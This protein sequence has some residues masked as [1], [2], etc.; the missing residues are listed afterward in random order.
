MSIGPRGQPVSGLAAATVL[1]YC[2]ST[3]V[4]ERYKKSGQEASS[5]KVWERS[6]VEKAVERGQERYR[7][8]SSKRAITV[9]WLPYTVPYYRT[10]I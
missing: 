1:S 5:L 8:L 7:L 9:S 10:K 6:K 2:Y 3:F 4:Q